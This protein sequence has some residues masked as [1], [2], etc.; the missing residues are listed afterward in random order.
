MARFP[1][2]YFRSDRGTRCLQP[3][4]R[5]ITLD[6]DKATVLAKYH[7]LMASEGRAKP[8][9]NL[10]VY[11]PAEVF[12]DHSLS[13][14]AQGSSG[15]SQNHSRESGGNPPPGPERICRHVDR[16]Q[17][18]NLDQAVHLLRSDAKTLSNF[19]KGRHSS[20]LPHLTEYTLYKPCTPTLS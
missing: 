2:P 3:G 1:K 19:R 4:K 5:Q 13:M 14:Y 15:S 12:L 20:G 9:L 8:S 17:P 10:T 16:C 11:Q 18:P 6:R 7:S